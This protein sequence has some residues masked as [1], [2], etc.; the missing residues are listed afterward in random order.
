M[1]LENTIWLLQSFENHTE[2]NMDILEA[3]EMIHYFQ[4]CL[5]SIHCIYEANDSRNLSTTSE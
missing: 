4:M 3:N 1:Y 2:L 5:F